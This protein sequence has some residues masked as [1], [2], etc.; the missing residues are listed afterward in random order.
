MVIAAFADEFQDYFFPPPPEAL[1]VATVDC[2][3][4]SEG[5][6]EAAF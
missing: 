6:A 5:R 2:F 3:T 4:F 1:A